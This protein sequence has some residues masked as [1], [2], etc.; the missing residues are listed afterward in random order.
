MQIYEFLISK[1]IIHLCIFLFTSIR[2][3]L[4]SYTN[5]KWFY[6]NNARSY[7]TIAYPRL[8]L[9]LNIVSAYGLCF[10]HKSSIWKRLNQLTGP[11]V[12]TTTFR[13]VVQW[14]IDCSN[15]LESLPSW[16]MLGLTEMKCDDRKAWW[17]CGILSSRRPQCPC[18]EWFWIHSTNS[19][20][21]LCAGKS[22][23]TTDKE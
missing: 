19:G 11:L 17:S 13:S 3:F 21:F 12:I 22:S 8:H 10:I 18:S 7:Y 1:I 23:A 9:Y 14:K 20:L 2:F 6:V 4:H 16:T 15:R 5:V